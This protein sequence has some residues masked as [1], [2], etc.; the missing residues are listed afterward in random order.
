M[1]FPGEKSFAFSILDDTDDSTVRNVRPIYELLAEL[2]IRTT[3]T[4]WSLE[5]SR[6]SRQFF[7]GDTLQKAGYLEFVH[8]LVERGVELAWHCASKE[9]SA[10]TRTLEAFDYFSREFGFVPE[11]HCNHGSNQENLYWGPDRYRNA[12]VRFVMRMY[13]KLRRAPE[14]SGEAPDSPYFWGDLCK[15]HIRFVRNYTFSDIN[16]LKND[17]HMPY[18]LNS[19]PY[20][21]YWFSTADAPNVRDF[22]RLFTKENIDRLERERGICILSTHLGKGFVKDGSVNAETEDALRYLASRNGWF[23]PVSEIL[24]FLLARNRG[25]ELP[26]RQQLGLEYRH[27]IDRLKT[28]LA[29]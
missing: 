24:E 21:Q 23:V 26:R 1:D 7:A 15:Q 5:S 19:T 28:R 22:N 29:A 25:P 13:A 18:H 3:K 2:G 4:V 8:E 14:F 6:P 10:R 9:S 17:P 20:V 11:I 12:I 16:V 27:V